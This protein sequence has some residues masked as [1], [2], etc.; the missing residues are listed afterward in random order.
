M[1]ILGC[2]HV[3]YSM[4]YLSSEEPPS[5]FVISPPGR[6]AN[7][8]PTIYGVRVEYNSALD[9]HGWGQEK[10]GRGETVQA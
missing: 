7:T 8:T 1:R 6:T 9:D 5:C 10:G 4:G 2:S 3:I